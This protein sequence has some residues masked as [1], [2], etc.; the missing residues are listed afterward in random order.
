MPDI[1][2]LLATIVGMELEGKLAVV[3]DGRFSGFARGLGVCQVSPEAA[4]GGPLALLKNGDMISIS[5]L[6]RSLHAEV[7]DL[8][9]KARKAKWRPPELKNAAGILGLFGVKAEQA[10]QGARLVANPAP[11]EN[12]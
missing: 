3:T 1:Y 2:A 12:I 8:D 7:S 9:W 5:L 4:V 10:H 6:D 11:W